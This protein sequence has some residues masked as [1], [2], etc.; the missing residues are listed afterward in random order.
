MMHH[1]KYINI[2]P[3]KNINVESENLKICKFKQIIDLRYNYRYQTVT[4]FGQIHL[5]L[6][7]F[8]S[9]IKLSKF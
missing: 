2:K 6:L 7:N 5:F 8:S 4:E 3:K 9:K 1:I